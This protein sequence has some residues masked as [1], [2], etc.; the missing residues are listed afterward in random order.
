[1]PARASAP[2]RSIPTRFVI[3]PDQF[4]QGKIACVF[5]VVLVSID[6]LRTAGDIAR[7]ADLRELAVLGKRR[8]AVIDRAIGFVRV[9]VCEQRRDDLDHFG[10]VMRRTR[11]HLGT[12]VAESVKILEKVLRVRC[13]K[14]VDRDR[15]GSGLVDD[16]VVDVG[17]VHHVGE[18]VALESQVP[19]QDVAEYEGAKIPDVSKI[20]NRRAADVHPD[21]A[22]LDRLKIL[23]LTR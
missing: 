15:T 21:L 11:H 22:V 16:P 20:P 5:L 2:E 18:V 17:Q 4:P 3:R 8:D 12:F 9:A 23:D 7:K 13:R 1:M 14:L 19:P 10:D 6:P